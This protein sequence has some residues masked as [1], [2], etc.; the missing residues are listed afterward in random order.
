MIH[1]IEKL[2]F[3]FEDFPLEDIND[4]LVL[5]GIFSNDISNVIHFNNYIKSFRE[6][7]NK[8]L[9]KNYQSLQKS[10]GID[11]ISYISDITLI[12]SAIGINRGINRFYENGFV[13]HFEP[14]W[15]GNNKDTFKT[16]SYPFET[17]GIIFD[18]D[19]VKVVNWLIDNHFLNISM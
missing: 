9:E 10:F 14:L 13:P 12:A 16:Y 11:N 15:K 3:E 7:N 18:L 8:I 2:K 4:Y 5:K 19:K 6:I 17:E 1:E